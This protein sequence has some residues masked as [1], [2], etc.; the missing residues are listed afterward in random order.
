MQLISFVNT[1][2]AIGTIL[3]HIF[4][5]LIALWFFLLKKSY[6][7]V[8][9]FLG[10]FG[11]WSAF[12]ITTISMLASLFYSNIAGFAPCELCWFQRIFMYPLVVIL[13]M[14]LWKKDNKIVSYALALS[15]LGLVVSLFQNY[16]Y[17]FNQG[18]A[19]FCQQGGA[20]VSCVKRY[21]FEFG[22]ISIPIMALTG[23][24]LVIIFLLLQKEYN[25][26]TQ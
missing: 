10:R 15:C 23:F 5:L 7:E 9:Q 6:P 2:L 21:V 17:Y 1:V 16:M 20:T 12:K 4:I 25:K 19:A 8:G 14:A 13:G 26:N 18:L 24:V 11:M 22:Y 3:A